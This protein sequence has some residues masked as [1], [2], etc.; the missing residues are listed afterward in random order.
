MAKEARYGKNQYYRKK[1]KNPATGKYEVVYGSTKAE[2]DDKVAERMAAWAAQ[3]ESVESPYVWEYAAQWYKTASAS[4]SADRAAA[5]ARE[6]ND[7]ILPVIGTKKLAEVNSDDLKAV[8]AGRAKL[9][10]AT[11]EKTRQVLRRIFADAEEAGKIPRDPA[12]RLKTAGG[13]PTAKVDALT[14]AQQKTLL[15]AVSGLPVRLFCCL[16][17]Y[18]GLRREE[19]CA[20]RWD[21]VELDGKAPSVRVR[22]ACRWIRNNKPEISEILKSSAAWRTVPIPAVLAEELRRAKAD[23]GLDDAQLRERCVIVN[24]KGDPWSYA[25]LQSAWDSV[26]ARSAGPVRRRRKD[27]A[28]GELVTVVEEKHLGDRVRNHSAVVT[29]DFPVTP[30]MLRHTY[31]TRLILGGVDLKRVQYLAGHAS[32]KITL[33]IYTSLMGHQP[34]DLIGDITDIFDAGSCPQNVPTDGKMSPE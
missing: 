34:E 18:A 11:Q 1:I 13:R 30:H 28:T 2:R 3:A 31:I 5:V 20:L 21:C 23:A 32:A 10:K 16:A 8:M 12:R 9:A 17:L 15:E 19:I 26:R 7:N 29:I 33:D 27:P 14:D 24:A 6:I 22:R 4:M 25:T